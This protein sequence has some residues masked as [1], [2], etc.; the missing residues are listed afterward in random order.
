MSARAETPTPRS[1][2]QIWDALNDEQKLHTEIAV[3]L[4]QINNG[5][6]RAGRFLRAVFKRLTHNDQEFVPVLLNHVFGLRQVQG[7]LTMEPNNPGFEYHNGVRSMSRRQL[8]QLMRKKYRGNC[9]SK[10][11]VR[12]VFEAFQKAG[13]IH[14]SVVRSCNPETRR[15]KT[16]DV[17]YKLDVR[18]WQEL[19]SNTLKTPKVKRGKPAIF[20]DT[21]KSVSDN[22]VRPHHRVKL[23]GRKRHQ[24]DAKI[25][26]KPLIFE[27]SPNA[28]SGPVFPSKGGPARF[29][30]GPVDSFGTAGA[31]SPELSSQEGEKVT[32]ASPAVVSAPSL[33]ED[34]QQAPNS[35][36]EELSPIKPTAPVPLYQEFIHGWLDMTTGDADWPVN[37]Y[38]T[39]DPE[40]L[41]LALKPRIPDCLVNPQATPGTPAGVWGLDGSFLPLSRKAIELADA[42][43]RIAGCPF[44]MRDWEHLLREMSM[45]EPY[46]LT[47]DKL[48]LTAYAASRGASMTVGPNSSHGTRVVHVVGEADGILMPGVLS[49]LDSV[50][51]LLDANFADR[52]RMQLAVNDHHRS[53]A[54]QKT[55]ERLSPETFPFLHYAEVSPKALLSPRNAS[56]LLSG[57]F[58]LYRLLVLPAKKDEKD[59]A[60]VPETVRQLEHGTVADIAMPAEIVPVE[61]VVELL[62]EALFPIR[63]GAYD[64]TG[65]WLSILFSVKKHGLAAFDLRTRSDLAELMLAIYCH[66]PNHWTELDRSL[67][68]AFMQRLCPLSNW[69][70]LRSSAHD[71]VRA[72]LLA[73]WEPPYSDLRPT[74]F[75]G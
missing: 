47:M 34:N 62:E 30:P 19:W 64:A 24:V 53:V 69:A 74:T 17:Y 13:L 61:Q 56:K 3:C 46:K 25:E 71:R 54:A 39:D 8:F 60:F 35:Q 58:E 36:Q 45:P 10:K 44:R 28:L 15:W 73:H 16:T 49:P 42:S 51:E 9:L 37:L 22:H 38:Y 43:E 7:K 12:R 41:A 14:V 66:A 75:I 32:A 40:D 52:H 4:R 29:A 59:R 5:T 50:P 23:D 21:S 20:S 63:Q 57:W 2:S 27:A 6:K 33:F 72:T 48:L 1:I 70:H 11:Q 65:H 68:T 55:V 18:H 26:A 31:G 67:G